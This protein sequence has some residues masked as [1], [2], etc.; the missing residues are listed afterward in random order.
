M[1]II[2]KILIGLAVAFGAIVLVGFWLPRTAHVE[3]SIVIEAPQSTVFT[4]LNGFKQ[5]NQWSPWADLDPNMKT[6]LEGPVTGVGAKLSWSGNDQV[7]TGSQE[8]LESTPHSAIRMRLA[9]GDF[10]GDYFATFE[11]RPEGG[12]TLVKWAFEADYGGSIMGRYFGLMSDAMV[13]PDYEKGLARLKAL[14]EKLPR[15]DLAALKFDAVETAAEPLVLTSVRSADNPS[16]I[17]VALGVAY[18]RLSGY[19]SAAGLKQ[20]AAPIAIFRPAGDGTV[21]IDA[22]I[23]VD[24]AATAT[25]GEVRAGQLPA[26]RAV[27]AEYQGAYTGLADA[28]RQLGAYLAATGLE[29]AGDPWEQYVSDPASTPDAQ[30]VTYLYAPVR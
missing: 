12:G 21:A 9:F 8:I 25:T 23:P 4:V 5:F 27:R 30:L 15:G 24:R 18:G 10:P 7:G 20:A 6:T 13:G 11:L 19:M 3:R 26:G 22:G 14:V 1:E 28:R 16:A 17:G 2:K 29:P